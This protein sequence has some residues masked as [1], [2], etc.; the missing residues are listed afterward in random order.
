MKQAAEIVVWHTRNE[1]F[2]NKT[3]LEGRP[4]FGGK[5]IRVPNNML[6]IAHCYVI[7]NSAEVKSYIKYKRLHWYF[8]SFQLLIHA[9][10]LTSYLFLRMHM[11][12]LKNLDRLILKNETL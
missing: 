6:E 10:V 2:E 3:I 8:T 7:L 5:D 11:N 1:D 9:F 4:I 12:K